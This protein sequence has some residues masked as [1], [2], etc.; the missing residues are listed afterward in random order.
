MICYVCLERKANS[1]EHIIPVFLAGKKRVKVLCH[2][3]NNFF[4]STI[5]KN[6][7]TDAKARKF[8]ILKIVLNFYFWKNYHQKFS[9]HK[10]FEAIDMLRNLS[11]SREIV[12]QY[13]EIFS[14]KEMIE[15]YEEK[16]I[17]YGIVNL[18]IGSFKVILSEN[19]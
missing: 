6:F 13:N 17:L 12:L 2:L 15:I 3:C 5:E 4:G 18:K 1:L 16:E 9:H 7:Y 11:F 8:V 10:V 14:T 19:F